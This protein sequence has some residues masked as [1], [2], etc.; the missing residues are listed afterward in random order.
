[1][2]T[3]TR[4]VLAVVAGLAAASDAR[5]EGCGA[6]LA[7]AVTLSADLD[8]PS[9]HGA[10]LAGGATL[11]CAGHTIRGGGGLGQYG[12][13]LRDAGGATVRNCILEGFEVGIRL[14]G[15]TD[16][17]VEGNTTRLNLRYGIEVTQGSTRARVSEN[18]V[19]ANGDEGI[20]VSGPDGLDAG[21]EIA[22][23]L[24]EANRLEG[25]Y[26][27][28]SDANTVRANTLRDQGAGG[29]RI[30]DSDRSL[31]VDN[32]LLGD[33]LE[34]V[35]A[36]ASVLTG[37]TVVGDRVRLEGAADSLLTAT[38]VEA[39]GGRPVTAYELS[40]GAANNTLADASVAGTVDRHVAATGAAVGNA[41]LRFRAESAVR[42]AIEPGSRVTVTDPAGNRVACG[43]SP[44]DERLVGT[45]L[46][47]TAGGSG[48][49]GRS[50]I[51]VSRD[52]TLTLG[53]GAASA[54]DPTLAGATLR[55]V[56]GS[57]EATYGLPASGWRSIGVPG[58]VRGYRYR[59]RGRTDGAIVSV[60]LVVRRLLAV[61]GRGG[62]LAQVLDADPS[63]VGVSLTLG[64]EGT[65]HCVAFG[66]MRAY[67]PGRAFRAAR[68]EPPHTCAP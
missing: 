24:V 29:V 12:V 55:V 17:V 35:T 1:M 10:L 43:E 54:D 36:R 51:L 34:L 41:V 64:E 7:G 19:L 21:H 37:N 44:G 20:H 16:A 6:T 11:D 8:C 39:A 60:T 18:H 46:E 13:Y 31:V 25:I 9:G 56:W 49:T 32:L 23:N 26:L 61:R 47:L 22:Q 28:G 65:R 40:A 53:R 38:R 57:G 33:P 30:K 59:A 58:A 45:R 42:C 52:P 68:A 50:F 27:L 4:L 67:V 15:A 66:G 48:S 5:S 3:A 2:R 14:R 63:P 62:G